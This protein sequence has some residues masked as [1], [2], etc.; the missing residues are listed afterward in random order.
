M[1]GLEVIC[2]LASV[3]EW[4]RRGLT[5]GDRNEPVIVA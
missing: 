4:T 5:V 3:V 2:T 1:T